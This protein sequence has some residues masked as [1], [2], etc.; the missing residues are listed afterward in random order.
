VDAPVPLLLALNKADLPE[1]RSVEAVKA[2][3]EAEL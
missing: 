1:S 3:L 2:L